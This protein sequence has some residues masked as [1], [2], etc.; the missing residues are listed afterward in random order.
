M[1]HETFGIK[2]T[3]LQKILNYKLGVFP[4]TAAPMKILHD[5]L[6]LRVSVIPF[7]IN[8]NYCANFIPFKDAF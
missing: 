1:R 7:N 5:L 3:L 2:L 6:K 8:A 4:R